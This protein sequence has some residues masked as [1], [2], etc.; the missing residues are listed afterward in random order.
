MPDPDGPASETK[1]AVAHPE[2]PGRTKS[3]RFA[4][5]N[6]GGPG[7]WH[8]HTRAAELRRAMLSATTEEDVRDVLGKLLDLALAGDV[9]A[10]REF[11][12][13]TIG[14]APSHED[15]EV[16]SSQNRPRQK[17]IRFEGSDV[18]IAILSRRK[19]EPAGAG[20]QPYGGSSSPATPPTLTMGNG[21]GRNGHGSGH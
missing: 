20:T 1:H 7:G 10:A 8:Y 3:G 12:D 4:V 21:N 13:R 14:K 11:L 18:T 5:G 19:D 2:I 15:L 9:S 16:A 17:T 6:Q